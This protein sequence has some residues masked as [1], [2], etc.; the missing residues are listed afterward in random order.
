MR[1]GLAALIGEPPDMV[2][3]G[4]TGDGRRAVEL[5]RGP[6]PDVVIMA[7]AMPLMPGDEASRRIRAVL[8]QIRIVVLSMF[9]EPGVARRMLDAGAEV[10]LTK[11]GPSERLWAA[12][13][14]P[15]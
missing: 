8:P 3:V 13:R 2:V 14:S 6:A 1:A 9:E 11:T 5:A 10:Y 12:I 4:Q 15:A 7:V